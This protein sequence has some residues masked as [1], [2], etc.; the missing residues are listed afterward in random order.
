MTANPLRMRI[1]ILSF[2]LLIVIL[3]CIS[4]HPIEFFLLK[5]IEEMP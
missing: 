2:S 5:S 4:L 3:F 1:L